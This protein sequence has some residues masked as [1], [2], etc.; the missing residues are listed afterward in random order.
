[1][2]TVTDACFYY[3]HFL[4][5]KADESDDLLEEPGLSFPD[6]ASRSLCYSTAPSKLPPPSGTRA[7]GHPGGGWESGVPQGLSPAPLIPA[8]LN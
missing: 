3:P 5:E 2:F 6:Q 4:E 1:M 7:S 8:N